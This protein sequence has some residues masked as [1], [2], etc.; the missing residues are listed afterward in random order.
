MAPLNWACSKGFLQAARLLLEWNANTEIMDREG[1]RPLHKAVTNKNFALARL[2][3]DKGADIKAK[4]KAGT[5]LLEDAIQRNSSDGASFLIDREATI[6]EEPNTF[7]LTPIFLAS[8]L[9]DTTFLRLLID[10]GANIQALGKNASSPLHQ[11][12][13][14]GF[15]EGVA[16]LL[17][18]GAKVDERDHL[19]ATPLQYA[20]ENKKGSQHGNR[21]TAE[22][23]IKRGANL[24]ARNPSTSLTPLALAAEAG[25]VGV[26]SVLIHG[27]AKIDC[28]NDTLGRTALHLAAVNDKTGAIEE[29][30]KFGADL[31]AR[32]NAKHTAIF[33]AIRNGKE[34]AF[35]LLLSR[36]AN[37]RV[38]G[39][40]GGYPLP[41]AREVAQKYPEIGGLPQMAAIISRLERER[42][43][44]EV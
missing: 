26:I 2:L 36:G 13:L 21:A 34:A 6:I 19:N 38:R 27:G 3:L 35:N 43:G 41:Y 7:G 4:T 18:R 23:L 16:V 11:A 28:Q 37:I 20:A 24:E 12:A 40:E 17:Q 5:T 42:L 8:T 14:S 31:E 33:Y 25:H 30:L 22:V 10:R 29:L 9:K 15:A 39:P 32:S 1:F 44:R